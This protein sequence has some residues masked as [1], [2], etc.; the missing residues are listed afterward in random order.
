MFKGDR[1]ATSKARKIVRQLGDTY[2]TKSHARHIHI[3]ACQ[4]MGLNIVPLEEDNVFQDL[5][6]TVH[7]AYMQTFAEAHTVNKI[8]ENERGVGMVLHGAPPQMM[9]TR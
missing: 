3:D 7:H 5:V 1:R 9:P 2:T 8:V 6:L 4:K